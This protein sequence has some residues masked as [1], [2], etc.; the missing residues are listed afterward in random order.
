MTITNE[1]VTACWHPNDVR[2]VNHQPKSPILSA[3][4]RRTFWVACQG[5]ANDN[6]L[7]WPLIP[8]PEDW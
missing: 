1:A 3:A 6:Q 2:A 7:V 8:F 4:S 5:A